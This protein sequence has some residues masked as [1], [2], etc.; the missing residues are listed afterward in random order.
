MQKNLEREILN[1]NELQRLLRCSRE[2]LE[3]IV[4][5]GDFPRQ[6][7]ILNKWCKQAV[8][9]WL[10]RYSN[11]NNNP[12]SDTKEEKSARYFLGE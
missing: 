6:I 1:K 3:Q 2:K 5:L 9:D 7:P 12:N 4:N 10:M 8:F 11:F